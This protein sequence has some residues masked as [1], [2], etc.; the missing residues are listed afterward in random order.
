MIIGSFL[1]NYD[2]TGKDVYP[3][4]QSASM[5]VEQS[6]E[7]VRSCADNGSIHDGLFADS[8]DDTAIGD[9][10]QDKDLQRS[11]N[12]VSKTETGHGRLRSGLLL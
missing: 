6:M 5:D 9:Y 3:F 11:M 1:E 7:F 12:S 10:V 4:A 2:L 8:H